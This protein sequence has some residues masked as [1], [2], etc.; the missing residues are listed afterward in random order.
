M[1][2]ALANRGQTL[3]L[4]EADICPGTLAPARA[5]QDRPQRPKSIIA[6]RAIDVL[7]PPGHR[8]AHRT[9]QRPAPEP[10]AKPAQIRIA[11]NGPA[12]PIGPPLPDLHRLAVGLAI[13][14]RIAGQNGSRIR[15]PIEI[16]MQRN[17]VQ[18]RQLPQRRVRTGGG[19]AGRYRVMIRIVGA[20]PVAHHP[21]PCRHVADGEIFEL[22]VD[23]VEKLPGQQVLA[24]AVARHQ[25]AQALLIIHLAVALVKKAS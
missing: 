18:L 22:V 23:L 7:P 21:V 19:Q 2:A 20:Q 11:R 12:R 5:I 8:C 10:L 9:A 15:T 4:S 25:I 6:L 16:D 1:G 24:V 13:G 3:F 17:K 14:T